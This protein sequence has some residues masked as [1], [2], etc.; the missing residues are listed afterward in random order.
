MTW[1]VKE[2]V[3]PAPSFP[4]SLPPSMPDLS[5]L[6]LSLQSPWHVPPPPSPLPPQHELNRGDKSRVRA[7]SR[8]AAPESRM[9]AQSRPTAPTA[10]G[11]GSEQ[12]HCPP[13]SRVR[14]QSKPNA[15]PVQGEGSEQAHAPRVQGEGSVL[16]HLSS[17]WTYMSLDIQGGAPG[18][19]PQPGQT[20]SLEGTSATAGF[21]RRCRGTG[22]QETSSVSPMRAWVPEAPWPCPAWNVNDQAVLPAETWRP[23]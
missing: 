21:I 4:S 17:Q 10:Q 7:Q 18:C 12:A 1:L 20:G 11:E 2:Q 13:E 9:R 19:H 16:T 8:P 3:G 22:C 5:Q 15:L 14:A 23:G 6:Y